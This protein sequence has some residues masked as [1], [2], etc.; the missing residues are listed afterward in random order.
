MIVRKAYKSEDESKKKELLFNSFPYHVSALA[1]DNFLIYKYIYWDT[2]DAFI[3]NNADIDVINI[4]KRMWQIL[5]RIHFEYSVIVPFYERICY[6]RWYIHDNKVFSKTNLYLGTI[7]WDCH[8]RNVIIDDD[9]NLYFIDRMSGY[10]DIMY[11]FP[12]IMSLL[13]YYYLYNNTKY[14]YFILAFFEEYEKFI[15]GD[16]D[17][18]Y[19]SFRNNFINYWIVCYKLSKKNPFKEWIFW[20]KISCLLRNEKSFKKFIINII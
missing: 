13:W 17:E 20:K 4:F 14:L 10:G 9:N 1:I 2:L 19:S 11:D 15:K 12:F 18:F 3:M 6:N 16:I 7:H 8:M 5:W